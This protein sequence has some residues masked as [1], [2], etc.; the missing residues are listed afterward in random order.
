MFVAHR[1]KVDNY[2]KENTISSFKS[3]IEDDRY[4][5]FEL[6]IRVSKDKKIVV[7]HDFFTNGLLVSKTNYSKLKEYDIPRL[8]DVLE[9]PTNK[10]ILIEIKDTNI[11]ID[12]LNNML[13]K[14]KDK[15]IYV[16][17]FYNEIIK[18]LLKLDHNYKC[19]ILNY[20]F[21]SEYSYNEYDFICLL[22]SSITSNI[23]E[24]FKK[25]KIEIFSYGIYKVKEYK[26]DIYYIVDKIY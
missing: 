18:K 1:G 3:A 12:Y 11:D 23:V 21:N 10:I 14:Y 26:N 8:S 22:N 16:V 2:T 5:G 20:I 13:N 15:N 19:G 9:L 6:D 7:V 24:Y 25:R 4:A 17:S